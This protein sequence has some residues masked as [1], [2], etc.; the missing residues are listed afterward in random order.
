MESSLET[1]LMAKECKTVTKEQVVL[2]G[3]LPHDHVSG[4]H[5]GVND[6]AYLL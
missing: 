1:H 6:N 3:F 2:H 5:V 4:I